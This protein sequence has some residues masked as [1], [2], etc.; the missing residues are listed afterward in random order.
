MMERFLRLKVSIFMMEIKY[1]TL[2]PTPN[3]VFP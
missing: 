2:V 1:V 3:G